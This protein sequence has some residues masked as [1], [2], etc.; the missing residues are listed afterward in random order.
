MDFLSWNGI[1]CVCFIPVVEHAV[2]HQPFQLDSIAAKLLLHVDE[3]GV[4]VFPLCAFVI[5]ALPSKIYRWRL[6]HVRLSL[7]VAEHHLTVELQLRTNDTL[8]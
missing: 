6:V 8:V 7:V 3:E 2:D 1:V 4:F 5:V